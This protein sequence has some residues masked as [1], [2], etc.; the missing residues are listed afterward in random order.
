MSYHKTCSEVMY[1]YLQCHSFKNALRWWGH[2]YGASREAGNA[3]LNILKTVPLDPGTIESL[4]R[5][6]QTIK[7]VPVSQRIFTSPTTKIC[8]GDYLYLGIA[9]NLQT[10]SYF[11]NREKKQSRWCVM[12]TVYLWQ[13]VRALPFIQYLVVAMNAMF[14]L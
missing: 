11:F 2:K 14:S 9:K 6:W 7:N 4:P 13:K 1:Q 12:S 8:G 3:L 10:K 5:N